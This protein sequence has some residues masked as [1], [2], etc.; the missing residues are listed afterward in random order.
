MVCDRTPDHFMLEYEPDHQL[1][2]RIRNG[3]KWNPEVER[4]RAIE[5]LE[6]ELREM[7]DS[8]K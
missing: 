5:A 4:K 3:I 7:E 1:A 6:R 8:D 2:E